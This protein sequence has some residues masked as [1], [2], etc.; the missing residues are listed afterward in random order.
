MTKEEEEE[1]VFLA[2][3]RQWVQ[4]EVTVT[5]TTNQPLE[6]AA[7]LLS[8]CGPEALCRSHF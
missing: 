3:Q 7:W 1:V 5:S 6:D 2:S 8:H 4:Q